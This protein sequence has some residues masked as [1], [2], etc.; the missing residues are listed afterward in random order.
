MP[1]QSWANLD[2]LE[3]FWAPIFSN[4]Q[5]WTAFI[6]HPNFD[7]QGHGVYLIGR[8]QDTLDP[9]ISQRVDADES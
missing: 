9:L 3:F 8:A 6:N 2:D 1:R 4:N 7:R 5:F